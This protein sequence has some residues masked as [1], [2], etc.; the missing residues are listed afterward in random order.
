MLNRLIDVLRQACPKMRI[1]V[2]CHSGFCRPRVLGRRDRWGVADVLGLQKT[3]RL[4]QRPKL[5]ELVLAEQYQALG[6]KQ[7][8][9]GSVGYAADR[10]E[11]PRRV[12]ARQE[13]GPQGANPRFIA[14]NPRGDARHLC[15]KRDCARGEA[16]NGLEDAQLVLFGRRAS[17]HLFWTNQ[18][19]Q[20]LAALADTLMINLRRHALA[21]TGW[22][23]RAPPP[24]ASSC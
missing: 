17:R 4:L 3:T 15:D 24:S 12:I 7:R 22:P 1:V 11:K 21:G 9:Y 2:R 19:R 23:R 5:A 10:W 14:T 16:E 6:T 20:L 13:H 8:P 18:L